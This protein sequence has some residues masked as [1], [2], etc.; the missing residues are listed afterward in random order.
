MKR[1]DGKPSDV[2]EAQA[3]MM[4]RLTGAGRKCVV[5]FGAEHAWTELCNY[6]GIKP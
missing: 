1:K 3:E 4:K 5:A 2:T 6:L